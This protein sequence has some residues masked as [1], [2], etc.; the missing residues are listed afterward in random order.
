[1]H[2][3]TD[4]FEKFQPATMIVQG[5]NQRGN[6]YMQGVEPIFSDTLSLF[7]SGGTNSAQHPIVTSQ[8]IRIN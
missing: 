3:S 5:R 2:K 7:Q 4:F 6:Q 8:C 1:M